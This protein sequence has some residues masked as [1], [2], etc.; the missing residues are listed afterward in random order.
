MT[1]NVSDFQEVYS[2]W[3]RL[4]SRYENTNKNGGSSKFANARLL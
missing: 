1:T 4:Y 3:K 2:F